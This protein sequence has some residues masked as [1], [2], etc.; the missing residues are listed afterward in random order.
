MSDWAP[1]SLPQQSYETRDRGASAQKLVNLYAEPN[2]Q[3]APSPF[4]LY[5]VPGLVP[6]ADIGDGPVRATKVMGAYLWVVS[7][8][9]LYRVDSL[10]NAELV[11]GTIAGMA[12]CH[13]IEN[14]THLAITTENEAYAANFDGV[15]QLTQSY[16]IGAAYQDGYGLFA[17]QGT[18]K[19][20]RTDVGDMTTIG[21]LNFTT[22]DA[23]PGNVVGCLSHDRELCVLS[24]K[25]CT[26]YQNVGAPTTF[27]FQRTQVVEV[28]GLAHGS[29]VK[30]GGRVFFLGRDSSDGGG[31]LK[32]YAT[33]GYQVVP[34]STPGIE[35][36]LSGVASPEACWAYTYSIPGHAFVVFNFAEMSLAYDTATGWWHNEE[37]PGE[38]RRR[39]NTC[40]AFAGMQ[41]A[42][43][44]E[45]GQLYTLSV[46]DE[47]FTDDSQNLDR[48]A[49]LGA[50]YF[51]GK[52]FAIDAMK[53]LAEAGVGDED[54]DD[55]LLQ[56][57]DDKGRTWSAARTASLGDTGEYSTETVWNRLG[58]ST[59]RIFR[60][61]CN[62]D[63]K[64]TVHGASVRA[65]VWQ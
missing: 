16:L 9:E 29:M 64:F 65:E 44:F 50:I 6:W 23:F 4:S 59:D 42:G 34:V 33:Q 47:A 5:S 1:L 39:I 63:V 46:G 37:S 12:P 43:D 24:E 60:I 30:L 40:T 54:G 27:P 32:I 61:R 45:T 57:S 55:A 26:F 7:G 18:P 2:P 49:T 14:G 41:I 15:V 8:N 35:Q 58:S 52:R 3:G 13:I 22:A 51:G 48:Y 19:V 25:H 20:F 36:A 31:A 53:L 38:L 11:E 17:R 56:W 62:S 28:G 10:G 21:A